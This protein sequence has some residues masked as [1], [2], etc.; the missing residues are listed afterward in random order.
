MTRANKG[1]EIRVFQRADLCASGLRKPTR[2]IGARRISI[3]LTH[4]GFSNTSGSPIVGHL[5]PALHER[6]NAVRA[7]IHAEADIAADRRDELRR[8]LRVRIVP[9]LSRKN[10]V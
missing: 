1:Y 5:A 4:R 10:R 9:M 6:F 7:R 3:P 8:E 2:F